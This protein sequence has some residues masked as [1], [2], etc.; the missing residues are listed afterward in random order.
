MT[1]LSGGEKAPNDI[2][3]NS[4][5]KRPIL[6]CSEFMMQVLARFG[7]ENFAGGYPGRGS[8]VNSANFSLQNMTGSGE[9]S[10]VGFQVIYILHPQ[11]LV[12][13]A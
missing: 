9:G 13:V 3:Q 12:H 5:V 7:F 11:L 4:K 2:R 1:R 6:T 10:K 8:K